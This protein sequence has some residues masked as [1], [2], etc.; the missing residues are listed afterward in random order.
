MNVDVGT[1]AGVGLAIVLLMLSGFWTD[2]TYRRFDM[3]PGHYDIAGRATRMAPRRMMAFLLPV[4]F[5][6]MMATFV[7]LAG[8]LPRDMQNG[9]PETGLW[10][11]IVAFL[12][13]QALVLWLLG[14]WASRQG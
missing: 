9:D 8:V 2:R 4:L 12:G 11:M 13:A 5:S 7:I 10:V 6:A 1:L 3:L 14:R